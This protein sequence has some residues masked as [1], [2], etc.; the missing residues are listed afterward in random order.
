MKKIFNSKILILLVV[1][2]AISTFFTACMGN[3]QVTIK[4]NDVA[5]A[6]G[7]T[8]TQD[9]LNAIATFVRNNNS[10]WNDFVAAY[11]GYDVTGDDAS[12]ESYPGVKDEQGN[13]IIDLDAAKKVLAKYDTDSTL[14]YD[15]LTSADVKNIVLAMQFDVSTDES[16]DL[17]GNVRYYIGVVLGWITN[18]I[19]FGHYI[20]GI[21]L[22]AIVIEVLMLPLSIKQ[23]KNSIKQ[24]RL[25]PKEMAIRNRYKGRNDQ[26]TQQKVTQEIQELY[27]RENFNPMGG[28]LPMLIQLPIIMI[29]YNIVVDPIQYVLGG[30]A[31]FA[32]ALRMFFT[33]SPAAG[34]LGLTLNSQNGTIELLS[35]IQSH[36]FSGLANFEMITN[37]SDAFKF[38]NSIETIPSFNIGPINF[39]YTPSL[40][41]NYWLL[42]V[43]VI[44]FLV[45]FFSMK[46]T[47]KFTYQPTQNENAPGAG[48]STKMMDYYMPIMSTVFC[49]MF[50]GAIGIYWVFRSVVSTFKQFVMS[51]VMPLPRYTEEDIKAAERELNAKKPQR[52]RKN[53]EGAELDPDRERPRSLHHIDDDEEEYVTFVGKD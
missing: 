13:Y 5:V 22:F 21:C 38:F 40:T 45:Y 24:A 33:A 29:L 43:P 15:T 49:F 1:V 48:C 30:S 10:A 44:T 51:K 18:T 28:C 37:G 42:V 47:R 23:Q 3:Q 8:L 35:Q 34:G 52:K 26:A 19:G 4:I 53:T 31:S 46:L 11:R 20:I 9:Q 39:G 41:G 27:E 50:P 16:R 14:K 6:E 32:N 7:S 2:I 17:L 36:D 25:R 12:L